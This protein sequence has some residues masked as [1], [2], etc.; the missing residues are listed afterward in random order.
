MCIRDS[1]DLV[2]G[3]PMHIPAN[4]EVVITID[5]DGGAGGDAAGI[6]VDLFFR[7]G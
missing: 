6:N 1:S 3:V 5:Y 2:D 4:T 7:E